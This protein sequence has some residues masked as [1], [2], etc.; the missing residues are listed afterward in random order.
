LRVTAVDQ[1]QNIRDRLLPMLEQVAAE[2]RDRAPGG[3]PAITDAVRQGVVGIE[4][5]PSYGFFVTTDGDGLYADFYF[6]SSRV[7]ARTSASREKFSGRPQD[8]HR[9]L[10]QG[11]SDQELRNLVAELLARWN[12][13]PGLIHITDT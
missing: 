7:D 5:D 6:R 12:T 4:I 3:Y 13:Q 8:D 1:L 11:L 9:P 2:Y 10:P